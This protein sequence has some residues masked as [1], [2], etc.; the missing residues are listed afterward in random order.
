[1]TPK[2]YVAAALR[3]EPDHDAYVR[4]VNRAYSRT[5]SSIFDVTADKVV[6]SVDAIDGVKK[7]LFYGKNKEG[8]EFAGATPAHEMDPLVK[9]MNANARIAH[10]VI[11]IVT[12]AGELLDS[13]RHGSIDKTNITEECGDVLWYMAVLLDAVGSSFDEAMSVNAAKLLKRY[14]EGFSEAGAINR[15]HASERELMDRMIGEGGK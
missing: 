12:E 9:L 14:S 13:V 1:V 3:T 11:G 10:G 8:Y 15:D 7:Y 2:E 6:Y 4:A 5:A